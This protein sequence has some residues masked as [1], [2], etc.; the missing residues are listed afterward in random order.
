[1]AEADT[2]SA[3]CCRKRPCILNCQFYYC[4]R[5]RIRGE[6]SGGPGCWDVPRGNQNASVRSQ[7]PPP[8]ST[9]GA[10]PTSNV[11]AQMRIPRGRGPTVGTGV[12]AVRRGYG[13]PTQFCDRWLLCLLITPSLSIG[14]TQNPS[15]GSHR[16]FF[17]MWVQNHSS[18]LLK[19]TVMLSYNKS[20][21]LNSSVSLFVAKSTFM[22]SAPAR[23]ACSKKQFP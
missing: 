17:R 5:P 9:F 6:R 1:M 16:E 21:H 23:R 12:G 22:M 2:T 18:S 14:K 19:I 7:H 10:E 20:S 4:P 8:T 11:I 13:L 15:H 3:A